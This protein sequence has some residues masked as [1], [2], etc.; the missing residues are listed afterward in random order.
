MI[1]ANT[2]KKKESMRQKYSG[3]FAIKNRDTFSAMDLVAR[4]SIFI[5]ERA[6]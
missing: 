3:L 2:R 5:F 6:L 4:F 1:P